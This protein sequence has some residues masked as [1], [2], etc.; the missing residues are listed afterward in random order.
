MPTRVPVGG[1]TKDAYL[2][3]E[4]QTNDSLAR[5]LCL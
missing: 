5:I 2:K 1:H 3:V 4:S